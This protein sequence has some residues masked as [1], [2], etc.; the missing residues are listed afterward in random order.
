MLYEPHTAFGTFILPSTFIFGLSVK[1]Q[2]AKQKEM[3]RQSKDR[4]DKQRKPEE[5]LVSAVLLT[6]QFQGSFL[7]SVI[8]AAR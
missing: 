6:R 8:D 3:H 7:L 1:V 5:K 4:I 2:T